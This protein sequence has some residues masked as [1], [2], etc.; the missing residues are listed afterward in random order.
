MSRVAR[1]RPKIEAATPPTTMAERCASENHSVRS[2]RTL[3]NAFGTRSGIQRPVETGPA[4]SDGA[5]LGFALHPILNQVSG[6]Q[7]PKLTQ[8]QLDR[9]TAQFLDLEL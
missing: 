9:R 2:V 5:C 8:L 1:G 3:R 4:F 7:R 6:H